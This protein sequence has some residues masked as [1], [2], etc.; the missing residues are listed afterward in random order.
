MQWD[1]D[2]GSVTAFIADENHEQLDAFLP[3]SEHGELERIFVAVTLM[4]TYIATIIST[5]FLRDY[6]IKIMSNHTPTI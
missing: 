5:I 1:D 6:Q 4:M 2:D 3:D